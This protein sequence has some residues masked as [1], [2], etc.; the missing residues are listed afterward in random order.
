VLVGKTDDFG[1]EG[2]GGRKLKQ[3]RA[4]VIPGLGRLGDH[5]D[6]H[7]NDSGFFD[8]PTYSDLV[9]AGIVSEHAKQ[10]QADQW[11]LLLHDAA[12]T[13]EGQL[14]D[15][16]KELVFLHFDKK[17]KP[18]ELKAWLRSLRVEEGNI[19][20]GWTSRRPNDQ[21]MYIFVFRWKYDQSISQLGNKVDLREAASNTS[22]LMVLAAIVLTTVGM[23]SHLECTVVAWLMSGI[24]AEEDHKAAGLQNFA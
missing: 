11:S 14:I 20:V 8:T 18:M 22:A 16:D 12:T 9:L 19:P 15:N 10:Q 4:W 21:R 24:A 23:T 3:M 13:H 5:I 2:D 17:G 6:I 7:S 1:C